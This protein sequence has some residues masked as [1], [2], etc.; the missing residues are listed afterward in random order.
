MQFQNPTNIRCLP[1]TKSFLSLSVFLIFPT[2]F[3]AIS[4]KAEMGVKKCFYV[5]DF[6]HYK[7]NNS[8]KTTFMFYN[9]YLFKYLFN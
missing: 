9:C 2:M 1:K 6:Y 7:K 8:R 4:N 3:G 5:Y